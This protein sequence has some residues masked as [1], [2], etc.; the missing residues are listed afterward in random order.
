MQVLFIDRRQNLAYVF[1]LP[2]TTWAGLPIQGMGA[3]GAYR[4]GSY[5]NYRNIPGE[6]AVRFLPALPAAHAAITTS[7]LR[8]YSQAQLPEFGIHMLR[9]YRIDMLP[10]PYALLEDI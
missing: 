2:P 9:N 8:S 10:L 7:L 3:T 6:Y 4:D 5:G 1:A